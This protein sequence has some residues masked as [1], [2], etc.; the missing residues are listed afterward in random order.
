M[1]RFHA[2]SQVDWPHRQPVLSDERE[3]EE[4][5][6]T[7]SF[8][9]STGISFNR[10]GNM[11]SSSMSCADWW[12]VFIVSIRSGTENEDVGFW[13]RNWL[14][15]EA[16]VWRRWFSMY[17][18]FFGVV[19]VI[20]GLRVNFGFVWDILQGFAREWIVMMHDSTIIYIVVG[21]RSG[22]KCV[23]LCQATDNMK[24]KEKM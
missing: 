9:P 7:I 1:Y 11:I 20:D 5:F 8:L 14:L 13:L 21:F 12:N 19:L 3:N 23:G 24:Q 17:R 4:I 15:I 2:K 22:S 10:N 6:R 16:S 18:F